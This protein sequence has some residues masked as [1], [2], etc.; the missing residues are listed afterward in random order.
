MKI[1]F[2]ALAVIAALALAALPA[3]AA[4]ASFDRTLTV[5]GRL[6]LDVSTGAGAIHLTSGPAGQLHIIGH[7]RSRWGS[8]ASRVRDIAAHPPIE[9]TGNIVHARAVR[10]Q[11]SGISIDY[12]IQAPADT[13]LD[14]ST[15]SGSIQDQDVGAGARLQTGS[16]DIHAT[17]LQGGFS[18]STGSGSISAEQ[19]GHGDVKAETGSGSIELRN[20][21]GALQAETGSGS[22]TVAGEPTGPWLL[23]TG[24]GQVDLS[25]GSASFRLD[26]SCGSG[27]IHVDRQSSTESKSKH[28]LKAQI[29]SGGPTVRVESGSGSIHIR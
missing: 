19:A 4:E 29:G 13:Y 6:E 18:L 24:S 21:S 10:A 17:G 5:Q 22:I 16:G 15:G 23:R 9:Q 28:H 26:A 7:V 8:D 2:A 20:L 27:S 11:M 14:A 12:D 1:R 3:F 25:T